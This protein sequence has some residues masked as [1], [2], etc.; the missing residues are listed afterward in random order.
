MR[1]G[2]S[3]HSCP[4][5]PPLSLRTLYRRQEKNKKSHHS[6]ILKST[7]NRIC[8]HSDLYRATYQMLMNAFKN[9]K[10]EEHSLVGLEL[11]ESPPRLSCLC[12]H[13][14]L[15][16]QHHPGNHS[17]VICCYILFFTQLPYIFQLIS[18]IGV[19]LGYFNRSNEH[20]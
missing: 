11:Q 1:E 8:A 13:A 12:R 7:E 10:N 5:R 18:A 15:G 6:C 17:D 2:K 20:T 3:T 9:C 14:L 19:Y 16:H 4:W